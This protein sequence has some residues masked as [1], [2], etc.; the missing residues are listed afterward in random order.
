MGERPKGAQLDRINVN[1]NYEP[2]NCRWATRKQDSRNRRTTRLLTLNGK[3][4]TS[5][6]WSE[7]L[8]ISINLINNRL[9]K[10]YSDEE[11]LYGKNYS[12]H[13]RKRRSGLRN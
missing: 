3:T 9:N 11:A 1:G 4:Q 10:G 5:V 6:D 13:W 2:R 8:N 12:P 7:E